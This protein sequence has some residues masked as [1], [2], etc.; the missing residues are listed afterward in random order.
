M[1]KIFKHRQLPRLGETHIN[2]ND[3][4]FLLHFFPF[5]ASAMQLFS[6]L[7]TL[8]NLHNQAL[9]FTELRLFQGTNS[10][11]VLVTR[12]SKFMLPPHIHCTFW[13]MV[14]FHYFILLLLLAGMS[15]VT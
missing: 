14:L 15:H 1:Y 4:I 11:I 10:H 12:K 13:G 6:T 9:L 3:A 2:C 5:F 8:S 7:V